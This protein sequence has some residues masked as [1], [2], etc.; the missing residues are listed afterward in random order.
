[1]FPK[2]HNRR[3]EVLLLP[4]LAL[5]F[6]FLSVSIFHARIIL[7]CCNCAFRKRS[8]TRMPARAYVRPL[9]SVGINSRVLQTPPL[10]ESTD[11]AYY[12][13]EMLSQHTDQF[14]SEKSCARVR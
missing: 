10:L 9:L 8:I 4:I 6:G 1:M 11:Q 3:T 14:Y 13:M 7:S 12:T 5:G 2:Q